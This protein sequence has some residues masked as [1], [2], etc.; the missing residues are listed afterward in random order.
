[1]I[2]SAS[3]SDWKFAARSR[4]ITTTASSSP[5]RKPD[6]SLLQ[7]GHLSAKE[8]SHAARRLPGAV[9]GLLNSRHGLPERDP[10]Q[11]RGKAQDTL[12]VVALHQ[13]GRGS[14]LDF[15]DL[16]EQRP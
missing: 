11:V 8:Y 12:P 16:A 9:D 14:F 3:R 5:V 13:T 2:A 10:V 15:G 4:K 6:D 1:M 7:G